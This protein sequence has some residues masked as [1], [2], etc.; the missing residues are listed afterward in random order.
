MKNPL[1]SRYAAHNQSRGRDFI[2][3]GSERVDVFRSLLPRTATTVLDLG[4]RDGAFAIALGLERCFGVDIDVDALRVAHARGI[5][6][7]AANLWVGLPFKTR[8]IDLVLG[9]EIFEHVPFPEDLMR[10]VARVLKPTGQ[11][12][13][14]VPNAFRLKN[15]LRFLAGRP[16]EHD[17]THLRQFSRGALAELVRDSFR[18]V[19]ITP[20]VG[21][22]VRVSPPLFANDLVWSAREPRHNAVPSSE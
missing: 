20:C 17:P 3:G 21:R 18:E 7:V 16:Y 4:C 9:G 15:R 10:E 2:Y 22:L 5:R 12:I 13:G 11:L 1:S 6:A 14:S 19:G 8:S